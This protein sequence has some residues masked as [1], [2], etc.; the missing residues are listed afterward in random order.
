M[1]RITF[2]GGSI[3][4]GNAITA[5]LMEHTTTVA[6]AEHS[7]TVE[8]PVLEENGAISTHTL[9]LSPASQF[10]IADVG[11]ISEEEEA[12]RFPV[13]DMPTVGVIANVESDDDARSAAEDFNRMSAEIDEGL[14]A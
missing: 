14:G 8:I 7:V 4:T 1:K 11:G 10:D 3:V 6:N 12:E 9:L 2:S 13:P 5:A